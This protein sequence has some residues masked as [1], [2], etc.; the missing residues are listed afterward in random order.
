MH[1]R[2]SRHHIDARFTHQR[3]YARYQPSARVHCTVP[4]QHARYSLN[5]RVVFGGWRRTGH[6][7]LR[8]RRHRSGVDGHIPGVQGR[9]R[10]SFSSRRFVPH[11]G[12]DILR[13][14][15]PN[16]RRGHGSHRHRSPAPPKRPAWCSASCGRHVCDDGGKSLAKPG[17]HC[18]RP[19]GSIPLRPP[20]RRG[21]GRLVATQ[22]RGLIQGDVTS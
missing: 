22:G 21:A 14:S 3:M 18:K 16:R 20:N 8:A 7:S 13:L 10:Q 11:V 9:I 17:G 15:R 1:D 6:M 2:A 19:K 12:L 5:P 4:N